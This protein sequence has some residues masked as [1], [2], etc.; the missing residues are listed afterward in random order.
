LPWS[1]G[2]ARRVVRTSGGQIAYWEGSHDGY[3]RLSPGA[4]HRRAV[5]RL[6][7]E[8]WVV[9][10]EVRSHDP[11]I[12]R[13]HWL[14]ADWP[15]EI[16]VANQKGDL[17]EAV[18]L[19]LE[20]PSGPFTVHSQGLQAPSRFSLVRADP[21]SARGWRSAYYQHREPA[22]SLS[23]TREAA[24]VRYCTVFGPDGYQVEVSPGLIRV[25]ND[26]IEA[27]I[28]GAS[29]DRLLASSVAIRGI[30]HLE[31]PR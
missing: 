18:T 23:L 31:L 8:H 27:E 6:G 17:G 21:F 26:G 25:T 5:V 12:C 2:E 30:D 16:K 22:V 24:I 10:D 15:Y 11:H 1:K 20:T 9:L 19:R 28:A 7:D 14:L 13:L 3:H 4:T 29:D